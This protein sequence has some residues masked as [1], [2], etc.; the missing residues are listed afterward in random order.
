MKYVIRKIKHSIKVLL[1]AL[2][3]DGFSAFNDLLIKCIT[4]TAVGT[5]CILISLFFFFRIP[6]ENLLTNWLVNPILCKVQES[7]TNDIIFILI[8][9]FLLLFTISRYKQ[10]VSSKNVTYALFFLSVLYTCYR[11]GSNFLFDKEV[12][13][14]TSLQYVTFIN[15]ADLLYLVTVSS[16]ILQVSKHHNRKPIN[17]TTELLEDLPLGQLGVDEFGYS[18][19]ANVVATKI[20]KSNFQ[21]SFAIGVNGVWGSGKSSFIDLLKRELPKS[22]FIHIDF[23]PWNSDNSSLIIKDFFLTLQNEPEL[24]F[25]PLQRLF[26]KYATRLTSLQQTTIGSILH[27]VFEFIFGHADTHSLYTD[28]NKYL[29]GLNKRLLIVIDDVDL[30]I[31]YEILAVIRLIRNTANFSN[32]IFVVAYDKGY[33]NSALQEH[34]KYNSELFLE[35]IIQLE[36]SLPYYEKEILKKTFLRLLKE[37]LKVKAS[38]ILTINQLFDDELKA[39]IQDYRDV[40]RIVNSLQVNIWNVKNL[41]SITDFLIIEIIRLKYP[42]I[43]YLLKNKQAQILTNKPRKTTN[44]EVERAHLRLMKNSYDGIEFPPLISKIFSTYTNPNSEESAFSVKYP[45]NY[46]LYFSYSDFN[47]K[48]QES[49]FALAR[50]SELSEFIMKI[51]FWLSQGLDENLILKFTRINFFENFN[52][53]TNVIQCIFYLA[54]LNSVNRKYWGNILAPY[55]IQDIADKLLTDDPA[56]EEHISKVG[57]SKRNFIR[58]L[59]LELEFPEFYAVQVFIFLRQ[60]KKIDED[61]YKEIILVY[62]QKICKNYKRLNYF[63]TFFLDEYCTTD[64]RI[65][66]SGN[67]SV[68]TIIYPEAIILIK[69]FFSRNILDFLTF[70]IDTDNNDSYYKISAHWMTKIFNNWN[71]FKEFVHNLQEDKEGYLKD[72]KDFI[73]MFDDRYFESKY[74]NFKKIRANDIIN[75]KEDKLYLKRFSEYKH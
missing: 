9:T 6:F 53:Y 28:I 25:T 59:F 65:D 43:F 30:L 48:I 13:T 38:S 56:L 47:D 24:N 37:K 22:E 63:H 15:Y 70:I 51:T 12:Y 71:S 41:V 54:R 19:Y 66:K 68:N 11:C 23:H 46:Y 5:F 39:I 58:K 36:I 14:F 60:S 72:F 10:H 74:Y 3:E 75:K 62:Y 45:I 64:V 35:K 16:F 61:L 26:N 42:E 69:D 49:E 8:S 32:T 18:K 44:V 67:K 40:I 29:K 73:E 57:D 1:R 4:S 52:D 31:K 50:K 33:V 27:N 2:K 21:K 34:N 55:P 7:W 20:K 17:E